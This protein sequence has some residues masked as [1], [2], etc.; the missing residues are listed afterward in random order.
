MPK[1]VIYGEHTPYGEA[2]SQRI[3]LELTWGRESSYV[4]L[5]S[6]LVEGQT[7]ERLPCVNADKEKTP[8]NGGVYMSLDRGGINDLIRHLRRARDQAF[9]RDE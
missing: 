7:L 5:A 6:L 4:Q 8:F 3:V 9:G 2:A 1:E